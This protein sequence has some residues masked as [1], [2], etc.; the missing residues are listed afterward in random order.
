MGVVLWHVTMSLDGFIAGP[1]DAMDWVFRH[2]GP[3]PEVDATIP[4]IGAVLAGAHTAGV[5]RK[6]GV[7]EQAKSVYGGAWSAP[8]FVLS[9]RAPDDDDDDPNITY[10]SGDIRAAVASARDA[11]GGRDLLVLGADVARQCVAAGLIDEILVHVAPLLLGDGVRLFGGPGV[12]PVELETVSV[13]EA[14]QIANLRYRV[15]RTGRRGR[16]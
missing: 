16:P 10:L 2:A 3:N 5:G 7:P 9:H 12:A 4:T 11:A 13:S 8:I 6:G 15:V 1:D 14:G